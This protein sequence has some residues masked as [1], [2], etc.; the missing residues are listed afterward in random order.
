MV[1]LHIPLAPK[2]SE[3]NLTVGL[4]NVS[5]LAINMVSKD[6][7]SLTFTYN[8]LFYPMTSFSLNTSSHINNIHHIKPILH[9]LPYLQTIIISMA[10]LNTKVTTLSPINLTKILPHTQPILLTPVILQSLL[11]NPYPSLPLYYTFL[12]CSF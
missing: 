5:T 10:I 11:L 4:T 1:A 8:R 7:F 3:P 2:D 9:I 6:M 12:Y